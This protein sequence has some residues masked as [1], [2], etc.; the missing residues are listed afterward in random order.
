MMAFRRSSLFFRIKVC[1]S[2]VWTIFFIGRF[3]PNGADCRVDG[4]RADGGDEIDS[5][6]APC[7]SL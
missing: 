3:F 5:V 4:F 1:S 6:S 7:D 2:A